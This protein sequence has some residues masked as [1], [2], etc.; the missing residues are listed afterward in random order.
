MLSRIQVFPGSQKH[1]PCP[2]AYQAQQSKLVEK[3]LSHFTP[4]W[5]GSTFRTVCSFEESDQFGERVQGRGLERVTEIVW[6][7]L[8]CS[9][10]RRLRNDLIEI[11]NFFHLGSGAGG[12]H[13]SLETQLRMEMMMRKEIQDRGGKCL[14]KLPAIGY[15]DNQW[16]GI[17]EWWKFEGTFRRSSGQPFCLSRI[18]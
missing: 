13:I 9:A 3:R 11:Y 17:T 1:Q 12:A 14:V 18:T 2:G 16:H 5:C 15:R 8:V 7:C 4:Q 10:W 6:V